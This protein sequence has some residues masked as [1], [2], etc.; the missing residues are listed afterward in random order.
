MDLKDITGDTVYLIH[1]ERLQ[2]SSN[3][4]LSL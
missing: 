2:V 1:K 4:D 3:D